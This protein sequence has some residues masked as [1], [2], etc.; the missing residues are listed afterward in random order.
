MRHACALRQ[1]S[2]PVQPHHSLFLSSQ[3][4][5]GET[6]GLRDLSCPHRKPRF[7]DCKLHSS[8]KVLIGLRRCAAFFSLVHGPA[9]RSLVLCARRACAGDAGHAR[10]DKRDGSRS[11]D[12]QRDDIFGCLAALDEGLDHDDHPEAGGEEIYQ[13]ARQLVA[14]ELQ[15]ITYNEF[16][17]ILLGRGA[18]PRPVAGAPALVADITGHKCDTP[19][20]C[21]E[22]CHRGCEREA[23]AKPAGRNSEIALR[24]YNSRKWEQLGLE[25]SAQRICS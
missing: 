18:L 4:N 2:D 12:S 16:L 7:C 9:K 21:T 11:D 20:D 17:P 6:G 8:S 14:A 25:Q 1:T 23:T 22:A 24:Q 3:C 5:D 13:F 10:R 15:A 19:A